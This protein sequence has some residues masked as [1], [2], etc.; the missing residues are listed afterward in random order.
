MQKDLSAWKIK[1]HIP[2][3]SSIFTGMLFSY[4]QIITEGYWFHSENRNL[5]NICLRDTARLDKGVHFVQWL[6]HHLDHI[7]PK[8]DFLG[9]H[10]GSTPPSSFF[11]N[12]H[13][14]RRQLM[15]EAVRSL[16]LVEVPDWVPSLWL[17]SGLRPDL[18]SEPM[19]GKVLSLCFSLP[20]K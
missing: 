9:L 15:A 4:D 19:S 6:R 20:F 12:V 18:A 14:E 7:H 13:P 17:W 11:L 5:V 1:W 16:T 8:L 2:S 3:F 10:L